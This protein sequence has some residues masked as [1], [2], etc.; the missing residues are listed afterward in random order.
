MK[1]LELAREYFEEYGRPMLEE[2]FE[3]ILPFLAAGLV[4]RGSERF[5]YDDE[6]SMD[7]DFEPGFCIFL[8]SEEVLDRRSAFKIERAYAKLPKEYMGVKRQP[9]SPVGGDRN[10][11][12]RT[13]DFYGELVGSPDGNL[14]AEAWLSIPDAALAEAVNGEVF[15]DNYGEFTRIRETLKNMPEDIRLKRMAGN[16]L[17]MAQAGQYNYMRCLKHNEP[18]AAQFSCTEF[19]EA[20]LRVYFL[21]N[22][23]YL[24]YYKWRFRALRSTE[25]GA[26]LAEKISFLLLKDHSDEHVAE[27]KYYVIEEIAADVIDRLKCDNLSAAICGDLEK[28]AY[29]VNDHIKDSDIRNLHIL[30]AAGR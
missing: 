3:D 28:H 27:Q 2:E 7:H 15:M 23:R 30:A 11:P 19:A 6:I 13:A 10:G 5:G 25:D 26:A 20:A 16:I 9:M 12:L 17:L 4:G 8:P 14:S 1:G 21:M 29:S 22:K 18:E 24:P